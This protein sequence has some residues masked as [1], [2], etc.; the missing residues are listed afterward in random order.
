MP[1]M[2]GAETAIEEL[3]MN[4]IEKDVPYGQINLGH[5]QDGELQSFYVKTKEQ[6]LFIIMNHEG[7]IDITT[8]YPAKAKVSKKTSKPSS[9][10]KYAHRYTQI[11]V[12]NKGGF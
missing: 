3:I 1:N 4:A 6:S 7:Y 12:N 10:S 8:W 5:K 9:N 2:T 11:S